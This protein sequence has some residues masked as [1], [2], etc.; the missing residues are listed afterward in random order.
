MSTSDLQ[1]WTFFTKCTN[2]FIGGRDKVEFYKVDKHFWLLFLGQ[3]CGL[4]FRSTQ[5]DLDLYVDIDDCALGH[6]EFVSTWSAIF[7]V[8]LKV[9]VNLCQHKV[10]FLCRPLKFRPKQ[11]HPFLLTPFP[12][13]SL[14]STNKLELEERLKLL[15]SKF[16]RSTWKLYLRSTKNDY[17]YKVDIEESWELKVWTR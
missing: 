12:I 3:N 14:S 15:R 16:K 13:R 4:H 7:N 8:D 10:Q 17:N 2:I 6:S 11:L 5:I 9:I 1:N